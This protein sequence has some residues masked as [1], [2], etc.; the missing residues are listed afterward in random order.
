MARFSADGRRLRDLPDHLRKSLETSLRFGEYN[1]FVGAG[2]CLDAKNSK[3][4]NLPSGEQLRHDLCR[5]AGVRSTAPLPRAFRGL[6]AEQVKLYVTERFINC[7]PGNAVG[8]I[9]SFVWRRIFTINIDDVLEGVYGHRERLQDPKTINFRDVF[10][11]TRTLDQVP[12]IHLHG[13]TRRP[14]DGYVFTQIDYAKIMAEPNA[15]MTILAD[16]MPVEPFIIS[17]TSLDE[18]DLAYY[19]QRRSAESPRGDCG[20]S[21][22]VEPNPDAQ[23]DKECESYG[24][25]LYQGTMQQFLQEL[26]E[27]VPSRS[28][29]Y[30]LAQPDIPNLF[31]NGTDRKMILRFAND[32]QLVPSSVAKK[33]SAY[34]FH[35]GNA[36]SWE[37]I[38]GKW[39]IGRSFTTNV[40]STLRDMIEKK[41]EERVLIVSDSAGAG[42]TTVVRRVAY[43]LAQEGT[44]VLECTAL[45]RMDVSEISACL[46]LIEGPIVI[47]LDNLAEQ[48]RVVAELVK[49][50]MV[51]TEKD[52]VVFLCA[53]RN[54]RVRYI[55]STMGDIPYKTVSGLNLSFSEAAQLVDQYNALGLAAFKGDAR[56]PREFARVITPQ[57]IAVACCLIMNDMKPLKAIVRSTYREATEKCRDRYLIASLA[58]YCFRDGIRFEILASVSGHREWNYQFDLAHPLP[59]SY[60]GALRERFVVPSNTTLAEQTLFQ[61]PKPD[62]ARAFARLSQGIASRVNRRT[63]MDRVPEAR[64]AGRLFD[65]EDVIRRFLGEEG[66]QEFYAK[67]RELWK[68]NSRYWEQVSLYNLSLFY[69]TND[70]NYM[71]NAVQHAKHAV[72]IERHPYP[73][74]TL[75]KVLAARMQIRGVNVTASYADAHNALLKAIGV[76]RRWGWIA[77][78]AY[79]TLFGSAIKYLDMRY[80][81][82]GR[83]TRELIDLLSEVHS[84]FP[85]DVDL[86]R[87]AEQLTAKLQA[88]H[89]A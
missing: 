71:H 51:E 24:L 83:Q 72:S 86:R 40:R 89:G 7:V 60:L 87:L 56:K 52:D 82:T 75:G 3:G 59:L 84:K 17:G 68:W 78:H 5:I 1:L 63:I 32:F 35:Y 27:L 12:I 55:G 21:F 9:P 26:N 85:R 44:R 50:L 38:A 64:L 29:P 2:V 81:L 69:S 28:H 36:P 37:D 34:R 39:D 14:N 47:L 74:T 41:I 73:L 13:W 66:A 80:V 6:S 61:A 33:E 65:Y 45:S 67:S 10:E 49:I 23:T 88:R 20:P 48:S 58:S 76:E 19:L 46:Q 43:E 22:Y 15:W 53:E 4:E 18:I 77:G 8:L 25:N 70:Q 57:P 42:K 62:I 30:D 79:V 16:I 11:E 54:Y 31:P